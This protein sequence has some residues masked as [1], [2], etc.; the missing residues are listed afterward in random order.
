MRLPQAQA[1]A[2]PPGSCVRFVLCPSC[3]TENVG[4]YNYCW[5]C[6]DQPSRGR[7]V[8]RDPRAAPVSIDFGKLRARGDH[9]LSTMSSRRA[10]Q[11]KCTVADEFDAFVLS[12]SGQRRG[13]RQASDQD[14]FDYLCFLDTQGGGTKWV[15]ERTCPGVG[16]R[17]DTQCLPGSECAK[18]YAAASMQKGIVSKLK[19]AIKEQLGQ[20]G[21]WD[22]TSRSGNPCRSP[23]VE[24]YL[25]FKGEEQKR[26]GVSVD[27]ADAILP[28]VVVDLL[29]DMR[30]RAQIAPS[31]KG[32]ISLTRDVALFALAFASMR[33]GHDLTFTL[34]SQVL[35][36]PEAQGLIFNFHFGKTLRDSTDAVLVSPD[37][38]C[39]SI[40][41]VAS[42]LTYIDAAEGIGWDLS[43]GHL[44][45]VV[46]PNGDRGCAPMT[47]KAMTDAL[48]AHLRAAGLPGH[49]TMHSFRV[50]GSLTQSLEGT[51]VDAIM[52]T[53][54]W[55]TESV[56]MRYIGPTTSVVVSGSKRSRSENYADS[57]A[58]PL[59][60]DFT[61]DF[62]ACV[63]R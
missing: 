27:Q 57:N 19:M 28:H 24:S 25:T 48:Q 17:N 14:V 22:P 3:Q 63:R 60:E 51:A 42:V 37:V 45:P 44:F 58:L 54:G 59:S 16:T 41:A 46:E 8:P 34:G 15:H 6:G 5:S 13:R 50:G 1:P 55:R 7:P 12:A 30:A 49:Y 10:Q 53:A 47:A 18:H 33:R 52:K 4:Q 9:V 20:D 43:Q 31:L 39:P 29:R 38:A 26:V 56:A 23:L 35:R 2:L 61:R 40:C 32:R 62:S 11:R 21:S 36:L